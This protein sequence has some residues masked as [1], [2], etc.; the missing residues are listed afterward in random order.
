MLI[1]LA[2]LIDFN[3]MRIMHRHKTTIMPNKAADA[4]G[5]NRPVRLFAQPDLRGQH[6]ADHRRRV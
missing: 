2:L 5:L 3:A 4:S 1:A 6:H